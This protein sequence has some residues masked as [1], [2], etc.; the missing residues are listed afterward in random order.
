MNTLLSVES[1][2]EVCKKIAVLATDF[3]SKANMI[4]KDLG[5]NSWISTKLGKAGNIIFQ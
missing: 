5:G 3:L 2:P 4:I 1:T